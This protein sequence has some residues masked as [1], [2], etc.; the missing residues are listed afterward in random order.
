MDLNDINLVRLLFPLFIT[1][2]CVEDVCFEVCSKLFPFLV[3]GGVTRVESEC[4]SGIARTNTT[5]IFI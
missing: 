1:F 2:E 5:E 4:R 3:G